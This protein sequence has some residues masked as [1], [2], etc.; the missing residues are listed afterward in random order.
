MAQISELPVNRCPGG[1]GLETIRRVL[2]D[3]W[4]CDIDHAVKLKSV[5]QVLE[6]VLDVSND[7]FCFALIVGFERLF[8]IGK[9][10]LLLL[11]SD[12]TTAARLAS[13]SA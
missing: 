10:P 13:I 9:C 1:P 11:G 3:Y 7:P 8:H 5:F 4:R 12:E 2:F 6:A